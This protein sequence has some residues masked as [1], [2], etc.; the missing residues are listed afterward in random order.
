MGSSYKPRTQSHASHKLPARGWGRF[1]LDG[2]NDP[3]VFSGVITGVRRLETATPTIFF[4]VKVDLANPREQEIT[5]QAR[6]GELEDA[7]VCVQ[8]V[9]LTADPVDALVDTVREFDVIVR[10]G[11]SAVD[12]AGIEV[13]LHF[14]ADLITP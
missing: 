12:T 2:A 7:T 3:S 11:G 8:S 5:G 4:R 9:L 1:T 10:D 13:T 6:C 14:D